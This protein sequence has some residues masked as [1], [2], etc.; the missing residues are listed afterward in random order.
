MSAH[1]AGAGEFAVTSGHQRAFIR[2]FDGL[3]PADFETY[4]GDPIDAER[5]CPNCELPLCRCAC[6]EFDDSDQIGGALAP[7]GLG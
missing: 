7:Y 5:E 4:E 1:R 6:H 3:I 2:S